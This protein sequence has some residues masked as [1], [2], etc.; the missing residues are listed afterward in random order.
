MIPSVV[1]FVLYT[2]E[3]KG[4]IVQFSALDSHVA[5]RSDISSIKST[6]LANNVI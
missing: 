4:K 3:G 5:R 1:D 2:P 6:S